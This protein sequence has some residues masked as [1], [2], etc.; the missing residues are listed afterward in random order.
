M[1]SVVFNLV[2]VA[3]IAV[4]AVI[5]VV[6]VV[7]AGLTR[8]HGLAIFGIGIS[9]ILWREQ[10]GTISSKASFAIFVVL[11]LGLFSSYF[12]EAFIFG[13][14]YNPLTAED[15]MLQDDLLKGMVLEAVYSTYH[16]E[17]EQFWIRLITIFDRFITFFSFFPPH[18][19]SKHIL[20]SSVFF[21][22][23]YTAFLGCWIMVGSKGL[24]SKIR[25]LILFSSIWILAIAAYVGWAHVTYEHRYRLPLVPIFAFQIILAVYLWVPVDKLLG[26]SK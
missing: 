1:G 10:L 9:A 24:D 3:V 4:I 26:R 17:T 21:L 8:P 22:P 12:L 15:A 7:V 23:W 5:A 11:V 20:L 13:P 16:T 2:I 14:N 6:A 18:W 25:C 19:S